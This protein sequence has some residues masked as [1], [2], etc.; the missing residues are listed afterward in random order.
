MIVSLRYWILAGTA[1]A[2]AGLPDAPCLAQI[3]AT[4]QTST[5]SNATAGSASQGLEE[6]VVTARR[7]EEKLQTGAWA[8]GRDH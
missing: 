5:G 8:W 2:I 7:R 6:I 4:A 3:W 1:L